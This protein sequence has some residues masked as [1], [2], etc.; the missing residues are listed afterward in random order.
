MAKTV[1]DL[2]LLAAASV[3]VAVLEASRPR[4]GRPTDD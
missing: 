1:I 3:L 2:L 4:F